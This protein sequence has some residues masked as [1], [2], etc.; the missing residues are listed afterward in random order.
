[1]PHLVAVSPALRR[2]W[3]EMVERHT[4][5]VANVLV[6]QSEEALPMPTAKM[7]AFTLTAVFTVIIDEFGQAMKTGKASRKPVLNALHTQVDAAFD[8]IAAGL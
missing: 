8:R 2:H 3:L 6:E 1:M 7:L 4:H 5:V